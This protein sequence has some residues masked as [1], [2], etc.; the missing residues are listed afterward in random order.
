[1][2]RL[3]NRPRARVHPDRRS[4]DDAIVAALVL[5]HLLRRTERSVLF[6]HWRGDPAT[7]EA[8]D[9]GPMP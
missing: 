6:E 1:M 2:G 7:L 5:R 3:A 4:L 8:I 9:S